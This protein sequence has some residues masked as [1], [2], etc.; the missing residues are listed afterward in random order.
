MSVQESLAAFLAAVS[1]RK[2]GRR[3]PR[4]AACFAGERFWT[5]GPRRKIKRGPKTYTQTARSEERADAK[6][7]A[8]ASVVREPVAPWDR[9]TW[10]GYLAEEVLP[11][12]VK[13]AVEDGRASL[14][15]EPPSPAFEGWADDW[16]CPQGQ[17]V[18]TE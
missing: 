4:V 7:T 9:T 2:G 16:A 10:G 13:L 11:P 14:L 5:P 17:E 3:L 15:P 8:R 18:P 12:A 1:A 6:R